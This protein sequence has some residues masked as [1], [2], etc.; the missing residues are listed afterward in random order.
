M[1]KLEHANITVPSIDAAIDFFKIVAPDFNVRA[2][3]YNVKGEYRWAHVGNNDNYIALQEASQK[4]QP[5]DNRTPYFDYGVNH[6]ALTVSDI[7]G[8]CAALLKREYIRNGE[9][10]D[11]ITRKRVYFFD[12]AGFEW[13]LV[14][15]LTQDPKQRYRYDEQA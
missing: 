12:K 1:T 15:Y 5:Q 14:E 13:E 8:I 4:Q 3:K 7:D 2:D 11:E 6:L 9:L 10:S